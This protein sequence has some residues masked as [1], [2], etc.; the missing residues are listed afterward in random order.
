[1]K[2]KVY[3]LLKCGLVVIVIGGLILIYG[4]YVWVQTCVFSF[5]DEYSIYHTIGDCSLSILE[6]QGKL[7]EN[8]DELEYYSGIDFQR[9]KGI[10]EVN[11]NVF[12]SI[13]KG[14]YNEIPDDIWI[15]RP[16]NHSSRVKSERDY[17][18]EYIFVH[19]NI[20]KKGQYFEDVQ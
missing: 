10:T 18:E 13:N 8:W 6:K 1:M 14:Y 5:M 19:Q 2:H 12:Q 9:E 15:I 7:P 16:I 20:N 3:P 4:L 11:F 17:L